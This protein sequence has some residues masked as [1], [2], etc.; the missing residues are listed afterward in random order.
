MNKRLVN[1]DRRVDSTDDAVSAEKAKGA[2]AQPNETTTEQRMYN[3]NDGTRD[4]VDICFDP[5]E[6]EGI[7]KHIQ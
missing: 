7:G 6:H 3:V 5:V 4:S 1:F 2:H